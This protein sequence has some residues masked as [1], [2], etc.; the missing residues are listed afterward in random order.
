MIF[1]SMCIR[2]QNDVRVRTLI[3][4]CEK[5]KRLHQSTKHGTTITNLAQK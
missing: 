4:L 1:D 3:D 5:V 2:R